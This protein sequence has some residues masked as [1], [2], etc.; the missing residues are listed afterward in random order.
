MRISDWSSDV[1]SS[2]LFLRQ[3][4]GGE[5]FPVVLPHAQS[6]GTIGF[7]QAIQMGNIESDLLG[8]AND[9]AGWCGAPR[10]KLHGLGQSMAVLVEIVKKHIQDD[11]RTTQVGDLVVLYA[12]QHVVGLHFAQAN[13]CTAHCRNGPGISPTIARSDEPTSELQ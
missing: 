3:R 12:R 13:M 9:R 10:C 8:P 1:C 5:C 7:S 4:I 11:R 6:R 2:D